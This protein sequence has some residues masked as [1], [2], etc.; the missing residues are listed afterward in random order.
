MCLTEFMNPDNA[1]TVIEFNRCLKIV[2][3]FPKLAVAANFISKLQKDIRLHSRRRRSSKPESA[4]SV[5]EGSTLNDILPGLIRRTKISVHQIVVL[6][7][8][9]QISVES[10]VSSCELTVSA[11]LT[12]ELAAKIKYQGCTIRLMEKGMGSYAQYSSSPLP[13][14]IMLQRRAKADNNSR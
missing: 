5:N 6:A 11:D 12:S 4:T 8:E 9:S 13:H 2:L 14:V 10:S 7:Q 3:D 1:E